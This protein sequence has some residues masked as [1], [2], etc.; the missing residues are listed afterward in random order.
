MVLIDLVMS[1]VFPS[2]PTD[3]AVYDVL[4]KSYRRAEQQFSRGW[5][6]EQTG[7]MQSD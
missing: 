5:T 6:S 4:K 7:A 2:V 3:A 1:T